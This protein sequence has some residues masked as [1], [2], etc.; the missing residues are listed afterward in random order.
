MGTNRIK[1][2]EPNLLAVCGG[3]LSAALAL[4][5][6]SIGVI[7]F[8]ITYFGPIPLFFI[9][10]CWGVR[11]LVIGA[12]VA[13]SIFSMGAGLHS[14]VVFLVATLAPAFLIVYRFQKG[15]PVG[16]IVSWVTGLAMGIFLVTLLILSAQSVNVLDL[17][18][19]WFSFFINDRTFKNFHGFMVPLLPG[20]SSISW[21]IA[22]F[23]NASIGQKL[24]VRAQLAQRPYPLLGEAQLHENWDIV[25]A[26]GLL[27]VVID[28]PLFAFIG[29]NIALMS[30]IPIFLVG[31]RV[32]YA[33]L[34]QFE[35]PQVWVVAIA[36]ISF[37]LVW[38]MAF[39]VIL[40]IL[41]PTVRLG[42][43][44][45]PHKS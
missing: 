9:G 38:P 10:M 42:Q 43:K 36:L 35:N 13:L 34:R 33:W 29:K 12:C 41:E 32:V 7:S 19:S 31:L 40:G 45:T 26:F 20:I 24:A 2:F 28:I 11:R 8:F 5:P 39:I 27:L 44:W 14:G 23:M 6:L 37:F 18:H 21:I 25:L 30:C 22:C 4:C 17:L 16:Y 15:D 1:R 3:A